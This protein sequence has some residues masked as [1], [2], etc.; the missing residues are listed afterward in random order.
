MRYKN[1]RGN[2]EDYGNP[3]HH[4]YDDKNSDRGASDE[5]YDIPSHKELRHTK[6]INYNKKG[7]L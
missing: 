5:G 4:R 2:D 6:C 7:T 1:F 3:Y